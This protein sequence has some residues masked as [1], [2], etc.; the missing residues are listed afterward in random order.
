MDT[1]QLYGLLIT[2][3]SGLVMGTSPWPL[4]LMRR[5]R[6]EHFGFISML[7]ALLVIP[8]AIT[9]AY[10]P[11]FFTALRTID[12][13]VIAKANA[14]TFAWGIA[15]VLAML[16]FV[17]IGVGL[18]YGIL[19]GVGAGVAVVVPMIHKASGQF[20]DAPDLFS[21]AG[22]T[23]LAGLAIMLTGLL[24]ASL[25][26]FGRDRAL[27][28]AD[29][30]ADKAESAEKAPTGQQGGFALGL[31][32]VA[33]AGVLSA[34]WGF[35]FAYSQDPIVAAMTAQG[36][37]RFPAGIAVW[38]LS[39]GGAV[40]VN[41][42]YPAWLLTKNHSWSVL[43]ACPGEFLLALTYG[44]LFFVPSA[45]LGEGMLRLGSLGASV[46]SGVTQGSLIIG[47]AL[48][49][50]ISGEWRGVTGKPRTQM[51]AAIAVLVGAVLLWAFANAQTQP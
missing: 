22:L 20:A 47:G 34:G 21:S 16:C 50:F 1:T 37:S 40:M 14:F 33:T 13:L 4:K 41:A 45:L 18:T 19:C 38:A 32:M 49:G 17:R 6:Y 51:Y 2:I 12:P 48:L 23:V 30:K 10:C 27:Q 28:K 24:L 43:G 44:L 3:C 39:F 9:L 42:L 25:A 46:G 11:H 29:R 36:A 15:Q 8:W 5:Y 7:F 31:I 26:G 35:A